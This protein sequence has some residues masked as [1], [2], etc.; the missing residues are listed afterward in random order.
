MSVPSGCAFKRPQCDG[1]SDERGGLCVPLRRREAPFCALLRPL[2]VK[3]SRS[4]CRP[5]RAA[6]V[7]TL[8]GRPTYS[9]RNA[10]IGSTR[11]AR[12][13]GT[14]HASKATSVITPATAANVTGSDRLHL[15]QA[16]TLAR[17][18]SPS[19]PATPITSPIT[20]V[21]SPCL[22]HQRQHARHDPRLTPCGCRSPA[23]ARSPGTTAR[24]TCPTA[25]ST[26]ARPPKIAEQLREEPLAR[27]GVREHVVHR[28]ELHDRQRAV[29]RVH[30]SR[31]PRAPSDSSGSVDRTTMFMFR[32]APPN[33]ATV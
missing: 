6:S 15:E 23:V 11:V 26:S 1:A 10:T 27:N 33:S 19:A 24:R 21:D 9:S 14:T 31:A 25:A 30:A 17:R 7:F 5:L 22:Q 8:A 3:A 13:A 16:A 28:A 4:R 29:H 2:A 32:G 12:R 18:V 20:V